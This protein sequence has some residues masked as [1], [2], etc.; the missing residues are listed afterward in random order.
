MIGV[1]AQV[2]KIEIPKVDWSVLSPMVC[3]VLGA[4]VLMSVI[5]LLGRWANDG[6]VL[7]VALVSLASAGVCAFFLWHDLD[8]EGPRRVMEGAFVHDGM[9]LFF[10]FLGL[11]MGALFL[12]ASYR[13][14]R[15]GAAM[16]ELSILVLLCLTGA[17]LLAGAG[18]LVVFF[19]G[20]EI[21]SISTYV[22][23]ALASR[24]F[25]ALEA[26]VKYFV[27]GAFS[28]AFLLYGIALIYG[29][30]G[31]TN[32]AEISSFLSHNILFDNGLLVAGIALCLV[33]LGFKI[34]AVPFAVWTPDVYQGA[35]ANTTAFMAS[36]SK[37]AGFAG[38]IRLLSGAVGSEYYNYRY[39]LWALAVLSLMVGAVAAV[40][41]RDAKRML[42]YS[43]V[44]H[45]GFAL[46]GVYVGTQEGYA[47]AR[48]Y[49]FAYSLMVVGSFLV[50]SLAAGSESRLD[51]LRGLYSRRPGLAMMLAIL[52]FAQA[53]MPPSTGFLAKFG[54]IYQAVKSEAY[55]L[56]VVAMIGS[57][58]SMFLYLKILATVFMEDESQEVRQGKRGGFSPAYLVVAG[59]AMTTLVLG[60]W[61]S[62]LLDF[63]RHASILGS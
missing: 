37:A 14:D 8:S 33:G 42:A 54:V 34:S 25:G 31:S 22:L 26:S 29:S 23:I 13:S 50:I 47:A 17:I 4:I 53:G 46:I 56:A 58:I 39:L 6:V 45:A 16:R 3:L 48:Y 18:D 27:M 51:S 9:T 62:P 24:R 5:A 55:I 63:A 35:N 19:L 20:L 36:A 57:V 30:T 28:S 44:A 43:S 32:T 61:T 1:L 41:Q 40:V 52:L 59:V 21:L 12:V 10:T 11:L 2:G 7:G 38:L 49:I 15:E 60:I